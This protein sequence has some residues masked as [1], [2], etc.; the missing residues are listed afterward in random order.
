[1]RKNLY[2]VVLFFAFIAGLIL[3][4]YPAASNWW[5]ERVHTKAI[6]SYVEEI[7]DYSDE[8]FAE[9]IAD[10]V[11]FN[12]TLVHNE[13]RHNM[14]EKTKQLYLSL[15]NPTGNG[16]MSYIEI[17]TINIILPI[18]HGTSVE[19]L[20]VGVGH[21]EGT[22]LP[23]GGEDTHCVLSSHRG[24]PSAK[25]FTNLNK[26][27]VGDVFYIRTLN[28][29]FSYEV[30]Q[31]LIVEPH[32]TDALDIVLGGD[33]CT[34]V[35]CTPYGVNSHRLLVRGTRIENPEEIKQIN[36]I[37]EAFEIDSLLLVPIIAMPLLLVLLLI[38]FGKRKKR[39]Y[40]Y[41]NYYTDSKERK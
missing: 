15:L 39:P 17:P 1:M 24:L 35:T 25:L 27:V 2:T 32:E 23:V 40:K 10:A 38:L 11:K 21:L 18:Y 8:E 12:E 13:F 31:I 30:D 37:A 5:N 29:L 9:M 22:S 28:E 19:V 6:A 16:I 36:V 14:D 20:Q 26:L 7:E 33:Y 3:L 41:K 4:V 34:L